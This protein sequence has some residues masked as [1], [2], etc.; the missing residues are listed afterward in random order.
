MGVDEPAIGTLWPGLDAGDDAALALPTWGGVAQ[1]AVAADLV[2]LTVDP[3]ERGILGQIADPAQQY[4]V[5]GEAEDVAD[6]LAF[7][8]RHCLGAR[9]MAVAA[10][11]D[12]DRQPP[13][14]DAADDM[15][16][17][18]RHLGPVRGLAGAQ[19]DRNRLAGGRFI[20]MDRLEA[21]S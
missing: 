10:H 11:H 5:A 1:F 19:N 6:A 3:A 4:R 9:V 7:A 8:P 21:A 18:Q 14:A 16:Q 15:A 12:V 20:D 2:G 17:H 13:G